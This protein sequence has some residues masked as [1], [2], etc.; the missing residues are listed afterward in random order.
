M[1]KIVSLL[2]AVLI[3]SIFPMAVFAEDVG[4]DKKVYGVLMSDDGEQI[5]I[6]GRVCNSKLSYGLY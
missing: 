6:E 1:R 5:L 3:V 4:A 2:L